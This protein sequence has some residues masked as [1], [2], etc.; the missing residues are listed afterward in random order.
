MSDE[1][2]II[3]EWKFDRERFRRLCIDRPPLTWYWEIRIRVLD[4][5]ISRYSGPNRHALSRT[6]PA[7]PS[8]E[9]TDRI[10]VPLNLSRTRTSRDRI[11][12]LL[13]SIQTANRDAHLNPWN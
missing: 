12:E 7:S 11:R 3:N 13:I 9:K 5:L 1:H 10:P 6:N 2:P 4:Y 8:M